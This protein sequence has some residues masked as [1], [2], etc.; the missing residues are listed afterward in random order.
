M[1]L[2]HHPFTQNPSSRPHTHGQRTN[3]RWRGHA[4]P[5]GTATQPATPYGA[6]ESAGLKDDFLAG[7]PRCCYSSYPSRSL[8]LI[9]CVIKDSMCFHDFW[10]WSMRGTIVSSARSEP[11]A[12]QKAPLA[13]P[14]LSQTK[15]VLGIVEFCSTIQ[16]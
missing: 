8:V 2:F 15:S 1:R 13:T 3:A 5:L 12:R 16:K 14:H 6:I 11:T 10:D 4:F 7:P 9:T